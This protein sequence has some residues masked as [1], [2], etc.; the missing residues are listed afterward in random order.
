MATQFVKL[1]ASIA[2]RAQRTYSWSVQ[3]RLSQPFRR[4]GQGPERMATPS[5][6]LRLWFAVGSLG[7]IALICFAAAYAMSAFMT[8]NLLKR[9]GEISQEFLEAIVNVNGDAMFRDDGANP[10]T[11]SPELLDFVKHVLSM[12]G[13]VRVNI[14]APSRRV[15]W[16]TEKQIVGKAFP[17]NPELEEAFGGQLVTELT[18][19]DS[20]QKPEHV[21]LGNDGSLIESYIPLRAAAGTGP[22]AGVI[23][24]YRE[25]ISLQRTLQ[26]GDRLVWL[27]AAAGALV[28]FLALY[29]IVQRGA[30]L[31]ERQ[32]ESLARMEAFAAIGQMSSAV[33]H[34]LR[35]PMFAIRSS[36]ELWRA[37]LQPHEREVADD[38]IREVDR[39]DGYV[40]DLLAFAKSDPYQLH[41]VEPSAV[42]DTILAKH[43]RVIERNG[44]EVEFSDER[45]D[46]T[47]VLADERLLEQALTSVLTNSIEAMP[48]GGSL[49]IAIRSE[50]GSAR[51]RI[52][53]A[54]NG[55][56]IPAEL[57]QRVAESYFTTKARGLGLG[58]VLAKGIVERFGGTMEILSTRN[59][60]TWVSFDLKS[61]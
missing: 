59:I 60:G 5:F 51:I 53:I 55:R 24:F 58:L 43:R 27:S 6:N 7:T 30:R 52:E 26:S 1:R 9:E 41:P 10:P 31:I 61:A 46:L 15:L 8:G 57:M 35:N 18:T 48:E 42:I 32:Q 54:D 19:L 37:D 4:T 22:I 12:P 49:G 38:V 13:V 50:Q 45:D 39:M 28:L 40:R 16:S 47:G 44:I 23:E 25:P 17:S 20:D 21:A 29:W 11:Q 14:H 3:S 36:A 2:S 33:A 56:G 34:S